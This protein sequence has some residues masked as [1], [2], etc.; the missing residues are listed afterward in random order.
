MSFSSGSEKICFWVSWWGN[1]NERFVNGLEFRHISTFVYSCV[2]NVICKLALGIVNNII[3]P[4]HL[5]M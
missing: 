3:Y 5:I 2:I 4:K 1:E